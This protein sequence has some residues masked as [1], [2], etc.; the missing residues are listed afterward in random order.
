MWALIFIILAIAIVVVPTIFVA[1]GFAKFLAVMS[2]LGQAVQTVTELP[3]DE[4][5][6]QPTS[7]RQPG[8]S[9]DTHAIGQ[10]RLMRAYVADSRAFRRYRRLHNALHR[11]HRIGLT[12]TPP[13]NV[14]PLPDAP[15]IP[16]ILPGALSPGRGV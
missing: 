5:L 10:A 16:D 8:A 14:A 4:E 3:E 9:K 12:A 6:F 11:W 7:M 1:I 15:D 13:E 2:A